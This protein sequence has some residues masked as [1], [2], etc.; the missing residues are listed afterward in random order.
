MT[1]FTQLFEQRNQNFLW[2]YLSIDEISNIHH[3]IAYAKDYYS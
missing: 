1:T 2:L 3:L